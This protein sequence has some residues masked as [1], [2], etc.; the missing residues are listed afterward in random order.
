MTNQFNPYRTI[1]QQIF[2]E[3]TKI[4][5]YERGLFTFNERFPNG[6]PYKCWQNVTND[7]ADEYYVKLIYLSRKRY[8]IEYFY[9]LQKETLIKQIDLCKD[10]L[11]T[12]EELL[13]D[14][15]QHNGNL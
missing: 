4:S 12:W 6:L 9:E 14:M 10:D 2:D 7:L 3:R 5:N 11:H 1:D 13:N 8:R 15:L